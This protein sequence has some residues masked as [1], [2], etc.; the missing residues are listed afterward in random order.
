MAGL[1]DGGNDRLRE[2]LADATAVELR[3]LVLELTRCLVSHDRERMALRL[4]WIGR[5]N[6]AVTEMGKAVAEADLA[7]GVPWLK[8]MERFDAAQARL[9]VADGEVAE[10]LAG[11]MVE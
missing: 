9:K 1:A 6:A 8:V 4:L 7:S 5:Q 11:E 3:G 10:L 2:A